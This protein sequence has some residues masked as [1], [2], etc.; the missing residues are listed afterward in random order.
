MGELHSVGGSIL[1]DNRL[2]G[3]CDNLVVCKSNVVY[4]K[5]IVSKRILKSKN[6]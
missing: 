6:K 3:T 5:K 1:S 2:S 4:L